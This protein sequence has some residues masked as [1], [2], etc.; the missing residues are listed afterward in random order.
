MN[1]CLDMS[2]ALY[3]MVSDLVSSTRARVISPSQ[4]QSEGLVERSHTRARRKSSTV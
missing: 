3:I 2:G 4:N 1:V